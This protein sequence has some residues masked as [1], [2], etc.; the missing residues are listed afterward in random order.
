MS[1]QISNS[2]ISSIASRIHESFTRFRDGKQAEDEIDLI[3]SKIITE[4]VY[5]NTWF[6]PEHVEHALESLASKLLLPIDLNISNLPSIGKIG[7]L[8]NTMAPLDGIDEILLLVKA[9]YTCVLKPEDQLKRITENLILLFNMFPSLEGKIFLEEGRIKDVNA[10]ITFGNIGDT[11]K[12]Y[13]DKYTLIDLSGKGRSVTLTGDE[14]SVQLEAIAEGICMYF[15]RARNSIKVLEVPIGYDTEK[16]REPLEKYSSQ[17]Q[18]NRYYNNYEYRKSAMLV[19]KIP[20]EE[21]GPLLVTGEESQ[22]G[23]TGVIVT[24]GF[25]PGV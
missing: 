6:I 9:G 24:A 3:I 8:F 14:S 25:K 19:N 22:V 15:G 13:F 10:F 7:V 12:S 11:F 23:F 4:S 17:L 21:L 1:S 2:Q 20:Y 18:H 16:L 5:Y